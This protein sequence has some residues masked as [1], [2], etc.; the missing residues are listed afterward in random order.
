MTDHETYQKLVDFAAG[1]HPLVHLMPCDP[2]D[3]VFDER[4]KLMCFQCARYNVSWRCPPRIPQMDYQRLLGEFSNAAFVWVDLPMNDT[5]YM[6][7]R[8]E[9]SVTLHRAILDLEKVLLNN[10]I[11]VYWSFIGGSCKLCKTG[12]GKEKCNNPYQA[13]IPLE[14]LGVNVV[15]S[16]ARYGIDITFPARTHLMR[17]GMILW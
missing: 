3:L 2:K 15:Q 7:V 1:N 16:A 11:P 8:N 13:R 10:N 12:C 6:D 4:V 14:A 17:L 5:T 9:S